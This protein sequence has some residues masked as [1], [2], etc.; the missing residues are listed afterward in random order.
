MALEMTFLPGGGCGMLGRCCWGGP[1]M[2]ICC[3]GPW[4]QLGVVGHLGWAS[5]R[6]PGAGGGEHQLLLPV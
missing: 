4:P 2:P 3:G 6:G 5:G 1:G